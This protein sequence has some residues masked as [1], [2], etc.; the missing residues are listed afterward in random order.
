LRL[1]TLLPRLPGPVIT[2]MVGPP[3]FIT[4]CAMTGDL[5]ALA[6]GQYAELGPHARVTV[7]D[8]AEVSARVTKAAVPG[9]RPPGITWDPSGPDDRH[10]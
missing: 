1:D 5:A 10:R 7:T 3:D 6:A 4:G 2:G 8:A 9:H